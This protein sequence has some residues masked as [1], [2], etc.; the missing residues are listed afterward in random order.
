[1]EYVCHVCGWFPSSPHVTV[2]CL[3]LVPPPFLL[4]L[5]HS[6]AA[7]SQVLA[8]CLIHFKPENWRLLVKAPCFVTC[9]KF[10][11][12]EMASTSEALANQKGCDK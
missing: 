2:C 6:S 9:A 1:M 4:F 7:L 11:P 3:V 5:Q 8:L 10:Q 12:L